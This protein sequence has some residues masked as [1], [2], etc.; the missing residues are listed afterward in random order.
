M[1][2]AFHEEM[3]RLELLE[4]MDMETSPEWSRCIRRA[5]RLRTIVARLMREKLEAQHDE[6]TSADNPTVLS[7]G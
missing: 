5:T 1:R 7:N 2:F 4:Q 3:E 6:Q